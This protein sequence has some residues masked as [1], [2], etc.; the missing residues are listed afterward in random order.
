[1]GKQHD[2]GMYSIDLFKHPL[3]NGETNFVGHIFHGNKRLKEVQIF[4]GADDQASADHLKQE[5]ADALAEF[6]KTEKRV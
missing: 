5:S 1:M 3:P 2:I 4:K 6:V